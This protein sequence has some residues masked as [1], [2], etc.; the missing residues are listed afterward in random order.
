MPYGELLPGD[1]FRSLNFKDNKRP[2][3]MPLYEP[4]YLLKKE[5]RIYFENVIVNNSRKSNPYRDVP[6][7]YLRDYNHMPFFNKL[8]EDIFNGYVFSDV[9]SIC[10]STQVLI[11]DGMDVESAKHLAL[12]IYNLVIATI[13]N[14]LPETDFSQ[15]GYKFGMC[16]EYDLFAAYGP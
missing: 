4:V 12:K 3:T 2:V 7:E 6:V 16:S 8:I 10:P 9:E 1:V 11:K 5:F 15:D 13:A 14:Y